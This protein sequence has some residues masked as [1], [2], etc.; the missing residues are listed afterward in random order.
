MLI[1]ETKRKTLEELTGED[2]YYS[3]DAAANGRSG[4]LSGSNSLE[5]EKNV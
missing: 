1:P 4:D 3:D 5:P 2:H